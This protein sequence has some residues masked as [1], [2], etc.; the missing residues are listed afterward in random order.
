M[1]IK[2]NQ[3]SNRKILKSLKYLVL[4]AAI[5][6]GATGVSNAETFTVTAQVGCDPSIGNTTPATINSVTATVDT[7]PVTSPINLGTFEWGD[8][9]DILF[10]INADGVIDCAG[11]ES[12]A[13]VTIDFSD[14]LAMQAL[15][16]IDESGFPTSQTSVT[17]TF[18]APQVPD[19]LSFSET[20]TFAISP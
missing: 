1:N 14:G 20:I 19:E 18:T 9:K 17:V 2:S 15:T 10:G 7:T 3:M 16:S 12:D 4:T 6:I 8:S 13:T 11:D 5:L